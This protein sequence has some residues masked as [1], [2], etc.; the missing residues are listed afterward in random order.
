MSLSSS[1]AGR[2]RLAALMLGLGL[3]CLVSPVLA[4]TLTVTNTSDSGPGSLRSAIANAVSGTT[5]VFDP[6]V[7]AAKQVISLTTGQ[8]PAERQPDHSRPVRRRRH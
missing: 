4:G 8:P 5:I 7:F 6:T 1:A 3:S 2:C